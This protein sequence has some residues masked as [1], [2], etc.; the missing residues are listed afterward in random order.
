MNIKFRL[1]LFGLIAL[2]PVILNSC[3]EKPLT[4]S[5]KGVVYVTDPADQQIKTPRKGIRVY[6]VNSDYELDSSDYAN[7]EAAVAGVDITDANG[8]YLIEEI[9]EGN[10]SVIPV[11]DSIMYRFRPDSDQD[12]L[13]FRI[14]EGSVEHTVNFS[15]P[16]PG[17]ADDGFHIRLTVINRPDGGLV[18]FYRPIFLYNIVPTFNP[19]DVDGYTRFNDNDLTLDLHFGIIH[20]LYV[21]GNNFKIHA[22]DLSGKWLFTTWLEYDYFNTPAWSHWQLD[23]SSQTVTRIQ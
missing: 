15:A 18:T 16:G 20:N 6:A 11:P 22:M 9:P 3:W 14:T 12:T 2:L 7:N 8:E 10:Y 19:V 1:P 5:V 23:W 17:P 21:V 13:K 4:G